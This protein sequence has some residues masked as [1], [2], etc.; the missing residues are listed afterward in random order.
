MTGDFAGLRALVQRL[1]NPRPV[2]KDAT[3]VAG[4]E[5]TEQYQGDF[6]GSHDPWGNRWSP[7]REGGGRPLYQTGQ[8]ANPQ[9][10]AA[11]G[12][13]KV[14]PVKYWVFHQ[15]GANNMAPRGILPFSA[16]LWDPP[17]ERALDDV[18][19]SFFYRS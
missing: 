9:I 2:I 5:V 16:S 18:V 10:V 8:L 4:A 7:P 3:R 14:R 12:V 15:V 19:V 13:I 17:I 1:A 6:A 11:N